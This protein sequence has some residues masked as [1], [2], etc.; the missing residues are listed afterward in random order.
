MSLLDYADSQL[1]W[2]PDW[3]EAGPSVWHELAELS[4]A[5]AEVKAVTSHQEHA[6]L[7]LGIS[8][9]EPVKHDMAGKVLHANC[10]G[11]CFQWFEATAAVTAANA[12]R[13][14]IE[15]EPCAHYAVPANQGPAFPLALFSLI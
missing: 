10:C 1:G 11:G 12:L 3:P 4:P 15:A 7:H 2:H 14:H 8:I 13:H 6:D 5:V 9:P